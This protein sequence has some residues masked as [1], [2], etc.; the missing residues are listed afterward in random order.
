MRA[1]AAALAAGGIGRP[2]FCA[3]RLPGGAAE[4]AAALALALTEPVLGR[5]D[6]LQARRAGRHSLVILARHEGAA[7]TQIALSDEAEPAVELD[8]EAGSLR[9]AN[10]ILLRHRDGAEPVPLEGITAQ[11]PDAT[12]QAALAEALRHALQEAHG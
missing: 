11:Q 6:V 9:L 4:A 2:F 12:R 3:L 1:V 8:G 7:L 10:G 5:V